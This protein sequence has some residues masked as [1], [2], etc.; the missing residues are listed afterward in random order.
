MTNLNN[1][2]TKSVNIEIKEQIEIIDKIT[3]NDKIS[4]NDKIEQQINKINN[5]NPVVNDVDNFD[6][7]SDYEYSYR[8]VVIG[9][10][11]ATLELVKTKKSKSIIEEYKN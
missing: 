10:V 7:D 4:I 6:Y 2:S 9:A 3:M 5:V 11:G 8:V 1:T